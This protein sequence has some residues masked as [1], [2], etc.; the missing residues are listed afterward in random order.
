MKRYLPLL[1][2]SVLLA[3]A[4][5]Y[6]QLANLKV[7]TDA[8][9]DYSDM[10]SMVRSI[11][12]NWPTDAE[13][14]YAQFHW[15][16]IARRQTA[17]MI[18]H[19]FALADPI[20]QYNDYGF[21]MCSTISGLKCSVWNYMN[22]PCRYWDIGLHTV[23]D[24]WYDGRFHHYDNSLSVH[25]ALA[26]GKTIASVP[27]VGLMGKG[28]ETNGEEVR[29]Y[30]GKYR[31]LNATGPNGY[32]EGSDTNRDLK[33][34]AEDCYNPNV[35]KYRWYYYDQDRGHRYSLNLRAGEVYTRYYSRQDVNSP[36]AV[37]QYDN[38]PHFK[39]DPAYFVP[40]NGKDPE[41]ANPRYRIRGNGERVWTPVLTAAGIAGQTE[42]LE[43]V[44]G[45][46]NGLTLTDASKP[47][48]AIFKVEGA[49]VITSLK[50]KAQ[51]TGSAS[52]AI[53]TTNGVTWKPLDGDI[54]DVK[55]IGEVNG[56]Y[57]VLVKV[58]LDAGASL[59]AIDFNTIT[60]VNAKTQPTLKIGKNTVYVGNGEQTGSIVFW[61]QVWGNVY[62][63]FVFE[64]SNVVSSEGNQGYMGSMWIDDASKDAYVVYK[65]DAPSD[66]TS[67]T[68]G[69]RF[70]NRA[71][72][73]RIDML[74][75]FDGGKT[76][77]QTYSLTDTKAPWDVIHYETVTDIPA[78]TKSV[79][80]KYLM[81][82]PTGEK[83][84]PNLC[85]I[86]AVR[87]EANHKLAAP[88]TGPVEVTFDWSERQADYSLIKR[89]H[90]QL[91][92]KLPATYTINIGGVDHP[93]VDAL[94]VNL[95][96]SRKDAVK[97]GY[98]DGKDVGGEKFVGMWA[99]YGKNLAAHKPYTVSVKPLP[100]EQSWG[101]NDDSGKRLT[102][103]FV[104]S[105]YNGG[106]NYRD[107]AMWRTPVDITVDLGKSE[108]CK[109]FR[110]HIFGWEPKDAIKGQ[111]TDKVEVLTSLDGEN[112]TSIGNFDFNLRW[113][114]V[115]ENYMWTDE[116]TFNAHNHFF[117]LKEAVNAR[118]VKFKVAPGRQMGISEVQV[119]DGYKFDPFDLRIALPDPASNGKAPPNAGVSPNA[120]KWGP[121][122]KLPQTIGKQWQIGG[123][124]VDDPPPPPLP[125]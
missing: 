72:R 83:G 85:S 39:A 82:A 77:K 27:D 31:C 122:E 76:W 125:Q 5:A 6:A 73:A 19:G 111:V 64:E 35:L 90:T 89:S 43:N 78:G 118:Y 68:Y 92:D 32:L 17:P 52:L 63:N 1:A 108:A 10:E 21:L 87:M 55:L 48:F 65:I 60:Q 93:V 112:F 16:H 86:Y 41:A 59:Q 107:G 67:V 79:L 56:A 26:D 40:N 71:Q 34:I 37:V 69:G 103:T 81:N 25:Y 62:K 119:L 94:T 84:G 96:G 57:E 74:H 51:A 120:R 98:S 7:V 91:V 20:R 4:P 53:S 8:N 28:P 113:K 47:G 110:I 18:V 99:T 30:L 42:R 102:D 117:P 100:A 49:N 50:I 46:A 54:K 15:D 9:P 109:A 45:G 124:N 24:V 114:D 58:S 80:F 14:M 22:Y 105:P 13:K 97:L 70:Y 2:A 115:P 12:H 116:E 88:V 33:H 61:P 23:P 66:L 95:K 36:N 75:S 123:N 29:G 44:K 121:N 38:N 3:A 11:N 106:T 104:G 101:A